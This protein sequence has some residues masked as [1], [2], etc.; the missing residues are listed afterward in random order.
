MLRHLLR[1]LL[2]A[3]L[4]LAAGVLGMRQLGWLNQRAAPSLSPPSRRGRPL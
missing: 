1:L 3:A 4:L 2:V